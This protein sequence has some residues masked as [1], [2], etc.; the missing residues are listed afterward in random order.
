MMQNDM[1]S[2]NFESTF[3]ASGGGC[4]S[5]RLCPHV[6]YSST[7]DPSQPQ[8]LPHCATCSRP[9]LSGVSIL[10][11]AVGSKTLAHASYCPRL[12]GL[13]SSTSLLFPL[14]L[15]LH[16]ICFRAVF[17]LS[18]WGCYSTA[19]LLLPVFVFSLI[20]CIESSREC[21]LLLPVSDVD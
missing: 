2:P 17:F 10:D 7:S 16:R 6:V 12:P 14:P 20:S 18:I 21:D 13:F 3:T 15:T 11:V 8:G 19:H 1:S 9:K 4:P 5:Q